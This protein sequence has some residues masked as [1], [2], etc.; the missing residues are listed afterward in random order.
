MEILHA[1]GI[2]WKLLAIQALNFSI[3]LFVLW[4]FL[5][6]PVFRVMDERAAVISKGV[7]DAKEAA[8][9]RARAD[10]ERA[11]ILEKT[12]EESG[13][14]AEELHRQ[15]VESHREALRKATEQVDV[16]ITEARVQGRAEQEAMRRES[17]R[18]VARLAIL[19][20][21]KIIRDR[22]TTSA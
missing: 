2:E 1:F 19:S 21:E 12:R 16:I 5:Y 6:R 8:E 14:L 7:E 15:A 9:L 10:A 13:K 3:V 20:A 4:R 22:V 17:E 18:E 11:A